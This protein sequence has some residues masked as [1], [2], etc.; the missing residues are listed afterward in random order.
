[1]QCEVW[2]VK[3]AVRSEKFGVR[4]VQCEVWS[5]ECEDFASSL[6][7]K[8]TVCRGKDTVGTGCLWTIGHLCLGNFRRRLARVYVIPYH[9]P[10]NPIKSHYICIYIYTYMHICWHILDGLLSPFPRLR[11]HLPGQQPRHAQVPRPGW[12]RP[13]DS[14]G[15]LPSRLRPV[16]TL[17]LDCL[18]TSNFLSFEFQISPT[19]IWSMFFFKDLK[20]LPVYVD[21]LF[22]CGNRKSR[23][24]TPVGRCFVKKR[25]VGLICKLPGKNLV[26]G[27]E[28]WNF[29]TFHILGIAT[30]TD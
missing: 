20:M 25:W 27:L 10:L 17:W 2:S 4:R 22:W 18:E 13:G 21:K 24:Q 11:R 6:A 16:S 8:K 9:I 7:E 29:M 28:P 14:G 23:T 30:P 3:E 5:V 15:L 19:N 26:G 1:M 12:E